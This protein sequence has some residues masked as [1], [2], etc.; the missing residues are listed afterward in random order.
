MR[1]GVKMGCG[2]TVGLSTFE[3]SNPTKGEAICNCDLVVPSRG[4][5]RPERL[6][7][8]PMSRRSRPRVLLLRPPAVFRNR[9]FPDGPRLELPLGP[10]YLAAILE[11]HDIDVQVFDALAEPELAAAPSR[12]PTIRFGAAPERMRARIAAARPDVVG[13]NNPFTDHLPFALEAARLV[14]EA[15]PA[16]HVV[17]GGPHATNDPES[18]LAAEP[19][20]DVAFR[21]EGETSFADLVRALAGGDSLDAIA[22]AVF[23][24]DGARVHGAPP[25][26]VADV[27]SLPFPGYHYVDLER[28]FE[29]FARGFASKFAFGRPGSNRRVSLITSR[30]CP[31]RCSFCDAPRLAGHAFRA[32]SPDYVIEHV[33][34]LRGRFDVRHLHINDDNLTAN[35]ARFREILEGFRR[36]LPGLTWDTPNGVRADDLD[37]DLVALAKEAG[38]TYLILGV[39]SGDADVLERIVDKRLSLDAVIAA[40]RACHR[41]GL[42]VHAFYLL[43]MPGETRATMQR[44]LDFARFLL[45]S[46][47]VVPHV[48]VVEPHVGTR[49]HEIATE[50]GYLTAPL[51]SAASKKSIAAHTHPFAHITTPEFRA[52][53]L[54]D[55]R[56]RFMSESL[57]VLGRNAARLLATRPRLALGTALYFL[58][59]WW[60]SPLRPLAS[61]R[62]TLMDRLLFPRL[63]TTPH[64]A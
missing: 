40:A 8:I 63:L 25:V 60:R 39:E 62:A 57:G 48:N 32:H 45:T 5:P 58:G 22:G 52:D 2:E 35:R 47:G 17:V 12:T 31:Y 28:Y 18:I 23:R 20:V 27:D 29:L 36:E 54:L 59:R 50:S 43:G 49:V 33:R 53:E 7:P 51:A 46:Y 3:P 30:G 19:A 56:D 21:G 9:P 15:A 44:T 41:V 34:F 24:R 11:Q 16:A 55:L 10:L 38:C 13:I 1:V 4:S 6:R 14:R 42:D 64:P 26:R 37:E 61:L